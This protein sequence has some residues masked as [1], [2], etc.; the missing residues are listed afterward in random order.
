MF[1]ESTSGAIEGVDLGDHIQELSSKVSQTIHQRAGELIAP[2]SKP[3]ILME[4]LQAIT[5]GKKLPSVSI[6]ISERSIGRQTPDPAAESELGKILV[7]LGFPVVDPTKN[8]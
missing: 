1:G 6:S 2:T 5:K 8:G 3:D 4:R 7:K